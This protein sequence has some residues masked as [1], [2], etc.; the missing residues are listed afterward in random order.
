M[1]AMITCER[2]GS[3]VPAGSSVCPNCGAPVSSSTQA[4]EWVQTDAQP[5]ARD[6]ETI[7]LAEEEPAQEL[8]VPPRPVDK[9]ESPASQPEVS[10]TP[11][12]PTFQPQN[13]ASPATPQKKSNLVL[14]IVGGCVALFL[15]CCCISVIGAALYIYS[16][17]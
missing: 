8:P 11:P 9:V 5:S 10:Y 3:N 12:Q 2:C 14:W 6:K 17:R 1:S 7:K 13:L 4:E 15:L 16:V